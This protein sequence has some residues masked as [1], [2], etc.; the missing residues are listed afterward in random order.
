MSTH[1]NVSPTNSQ[2]PLT[3]TQALTLIPILANQ[4]KYTNSTH[5]SQRISQPDRSFTESR[6]LFILKY[7]KTVSIPIWSNKHNDYTCKVQGHNKRHAVVA[8]KNDNTEM[9]IVT[10]F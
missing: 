4:S 5:A 3:P 7:P 10:V 1:P 9:V 6:L 2:S 8:L